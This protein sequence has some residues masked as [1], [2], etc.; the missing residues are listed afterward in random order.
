MRAK[1]AQEASQLL[2][3]GLLMLP[4][5]L[6]L[7]STVFLRGKGDEL[8]NLDIPLILLVVTAVLLVVTGVLV[9]AAMRRFQR[10]RLVFD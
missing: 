10:S 1:T 4:L 6:G 8:A 5:G 2:I 7:A 3:G 9:W